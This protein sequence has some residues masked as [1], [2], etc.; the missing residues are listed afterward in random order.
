MAEY[1]YVMKERAETL[2]IKHGL[3][4]AE[5]ARITG[6]AE[7]TLNRWARTGGKKVKGKYI[8]GWR[9]RQQKYQEKKRTIDEN[10]FA[11]LDKLSK[12][13]KKNVDSQGVY[14][15]V[16]LYKL[17]AQ[18][19]EQARPEPLDKVRVFMMVFEWLLKYY[20]EKQPDVFKVLGDGVDE[21]VQE[22]KKW[23]QRVD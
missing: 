18:S 14:A 16:Q 3:S 6:I 10:L 8:N 21:V 23:A 17:Q 2:Y 11:A 12:A 15:A 7:G 19:I 13:V 20:R 22:F 1:D 5:I 4:M 9:L